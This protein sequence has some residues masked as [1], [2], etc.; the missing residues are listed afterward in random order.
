MIFS[1]RLAQRG[2]THGSSGC[3][4]VIR[5]AAGALSKEFGADLVDV[6][7]KTMAGTAP[8][9]PAATR[10]LGDVAGYAEAGMY[11]LGIAYYLVALTPKLVQTWKS[12]RSTLKLDEAARATAREHGAGL[13]GQT[14][15]KVTEAVKERITAAT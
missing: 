1:S 3:R 4:Q 8:P 10:S 9:R 6:T 13:P 2:T 7:E 15:A 5:Q 12:T 11:T 14:L